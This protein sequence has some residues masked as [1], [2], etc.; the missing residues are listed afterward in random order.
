MVVYEVNLRVAPDVFAVYRTW[1]DG[2]IA[3]I[4]ALDGFVSATVFADDAP[5]SDGWQRLVV[6]YALTDR[7]A[8]DRYLEHEAPR[9]RADGAT[10]FGDRFAA[11]RRILLLET[12]HPKEPIGWRKAE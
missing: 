3:E 10:R 6:H 8:L 1:L 9:L 4:L 11:T 5:D 7:A 2:H 12:V